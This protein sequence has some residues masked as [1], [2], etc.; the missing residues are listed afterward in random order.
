VLIV[1]ATVETTEQKHKI[2][3]NKSNL[4]NSRN[5]SHVYIENET[6]IESRNMEA[7][8]RTILKEIGRDKDYL[9]R[10]GKIRRKMNSRD[11][12]D[13]SN[14]GAAAWQTVSNDRRGSNTH[15]GGSRGGRR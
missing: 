10:N 14:R 15:R 9:V 11:Q 7:N 1:I 3:K 12:R 13:E 5:Y 2:V 4:R 6:T 8:M